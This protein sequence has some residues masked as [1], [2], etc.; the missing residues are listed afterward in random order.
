MGRA[1]PIN[2]RLSKREFFDFH[3]GFEGRSTPSKS[4]RKADIDKF[5]KKYLKAK[6]IIGPTS[7][8]YTWHATLPDLNFITVLAYNRSEARARIKQ[9]LGVKKL[10]KDIVITRG[11]YET[12]VS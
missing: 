12:I 9:E 10:P 1:R 2:Y 6:G 5:T 11:D 8:R 3:A 7:Q 4:K